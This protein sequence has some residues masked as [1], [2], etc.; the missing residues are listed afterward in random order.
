M[1]FFLGHGVAGLFDVSILLGL[2]HIASCRRRRFAGHSLALLLLHLCHMQPEVGEQVCN[3]FQESLVCE[4]GWSGCGLGVI[5]VK[6]GVLLHKDVC[7]VR[8]QEVGR[9]LVHVHIQFLN[10]AG[11]VGEIQDQVGVAEARSPFDA[12][13]EVDNGAAGVAQ[14]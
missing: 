7:G 2:R 5:G 10:E 13:Q 11:L 1:L 6:D 14:Q 4:L 3:S 8:R 9:V 12:G